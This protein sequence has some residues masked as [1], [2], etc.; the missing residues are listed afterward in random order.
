MFITT[1]YVTLRYRIPDI[2]YRMSNNVPTTSYTI[3]TYDV[4]CKPPTTSY[5]FKISE[6]TISYTICSHC[7]LRYRM[8][9]IRY[10]R[11]KYDAKI[12]YDVVPTALFIQIFTGIQMA[13]IER[14][15]CSLLTSVAAL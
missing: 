10:R 11:S 9:V 5:V 6:P 12:T 15:R 4:V 3:C 14:C 1:S 8:Y 7:D 2:R 13:R